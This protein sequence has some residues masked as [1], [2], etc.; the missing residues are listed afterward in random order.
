M[1]FWMKSF[2]SVLYFYSGK[3]DGTRFISL[4][5]SLYLKLFQVWPKKSQHLHI[6]MF[7][8]V[9]VYLCILRFLSLAQ[10]IWTFAFIHVFLSPVI[11]RAGAFDLPSPFSR[12]FFYCTRW[13]NGGRGA[14]ENTLE[15]RTHSKCSENIKKV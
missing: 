8:S 9:H 5:A 13:N 3:I 12:P 6:S 7:F 10:K 1:N 2:K 14:G 11:H 4:Q 15:Y